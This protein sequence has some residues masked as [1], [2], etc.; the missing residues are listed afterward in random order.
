MV[1]LNYCVIVESDF[2]LV[3][4]FGY[5][6]PTLDVRNFNTIFINYAVSQSVFSEVFKF[7]SL[8]EWFKPAVLKTAEG[9]PS[10]SSNLTASATALK[11]SLRPAKHID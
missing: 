4:D 6:A 7:G 5:D 1:V 9:K 3:S 2:K 8:G 11:K 10:V